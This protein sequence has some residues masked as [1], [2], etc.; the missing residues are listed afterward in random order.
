MKSL[1]YKLNIANAVL[2][3]CL[4][5]S[6]SMIFTAILAVNALVLAI[7]VVREIKRGDSK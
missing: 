2:C 5:D 1:F 4:V 6:E 7:P 3:A